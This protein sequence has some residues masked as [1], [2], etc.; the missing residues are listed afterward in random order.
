[1]GIFDDDPFE[2]LM[3]EFL[4]NAPSRRRKQFVKGEEED[5][6]IDFVEDDDYVYIV[7]ELRGY[8]EKDI[9]LN[10]QGKELEV[11]A[12]KENGEQIQEYLR[13][14]LRQGIQLKK[15][16]PD[17]V[18][19]KNTTHTMRNGVLEIVFLKTGGKNDARKIKVH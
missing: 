16:L 6:T 5:R 19:P 9:S 10:I 2:E 18:S 1:M 8:N 4:G 15:Q 7:F 14:K 12:Q 11:T 13:Q 17:F 3:R